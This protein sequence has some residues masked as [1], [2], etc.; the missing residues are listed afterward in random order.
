MPGVPRGCPRRSG[1]SRP[2]C[3]PS[4]AQDADSIDLMPPVVYLLCG[5]TGSGKTTYARRLE[6]GGAVRLSVDEEVYARHGRYGVDY[7]MD[8]YF[9]RERPVAEE[10]RRRL[11]ELV[12]SGRDVVL[13]YG[14]WRRSDRD[15]YKRLVEAHGGR[16]RLL[17]FKVDREVLSQRLAERNR[18]DDANALAVTPS[19]LA[20]F[21]ARFDEPREEGEELIDSGPGRET[22]GP[23]GG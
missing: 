19:A 3:G 10:L 17:Y 8:Q 2:G 1:R 13:D 7:S 5:L 12:E 14:L 4:A 9:D 23:T 20:D 16:W 11:V 22:T 21:I 18:R 6:A 15:A